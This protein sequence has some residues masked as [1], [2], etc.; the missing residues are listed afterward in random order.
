[1]RNIFW[2]LLLF[3]VAVVA[4]AFLGRNDALVTV[5]WSP[6]RLDMSFNLFLIALLLACTV[7]YLAL[8]ALNAL[9]GL[10]Q[11]AREWRLAK[12]DRV[13][14]GAL[15]EALAL[16]MS[17]RFTR[18]HK[19]AKRAVTIQSETPE[20]GADPE[21]TMLANLL[22]AGSMHRLQDRTRRDEHL[23][24]ALAAAGGNGTRPAEEGARLLAAEWAYDDRDAE[25]SLQLIGEL[26][27]G[28]G[29]RTQALR[30]KLQA[31]RLA[32]QPVDALK[33]ARLLAKHQAFS[34]DAAKGLLR[35]LAIEALDAARDADQLR[36]TWHQLESSDRRD[37]F[38]A[39]RAAGLMAMHGQPDEARAWLKPFWDPST[40]RGSEELAVLSEALVKSRH[41]LGADWLPR[42][43]AAVMAH[44]RDPHVAYALG[45]ALAEIK[46]WG[47]ARQQLERCA[48]NAELPVRMR[49]STWL[50]LAELAEQEGDAERVSACYKSAALVD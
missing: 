43:E 10:P 40:R 8:Q 27:P 25:R 22:A 6:W 2:L 30:L 28:V 14:Q 16:F 18:A 23:K 24:A 38:V 34:P 41:G 17:G 44:P 20:L 32:R 42:L 49:R 48:D 11:R 7:M 4:A 21:F 33:T 47:K 29:R 5:F 46:L 31:A 39:S 37:A 9:L 13:A 35:S 50:A 36:R 19:A 12:R 15:R 3:V 1:M 45:R 26:G